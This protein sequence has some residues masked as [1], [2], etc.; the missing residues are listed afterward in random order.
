MQHRETRRQSDVCAIPKVVVDS[1]EDEGDLLYG[2]C[3]VA[4][5][6]EL[7][8]AKWPRRFRSDLSIKYDGKISPVEFLNIYTTAVVAAG[9]NRQAPVNRF[10]MALQP[11]IHSWLMNLLEG[12]ISF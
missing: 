5:T 11:N 6:S 8:L 10:P 2:A 12:S 7:C 4:F 9:G 3:C 1:N